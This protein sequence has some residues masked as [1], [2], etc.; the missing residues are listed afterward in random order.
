MSENTDFDFRQFIQN[1]LIDLST[2]KCHR[3]HILRGS[4]K[5]IYMVSNNDGSIEIKP[6]RYDDE[7]KELWQKCE[8][9]IDGG[10]SLESGA[11]LEQWLARNEFVLPSQYLNDLSAGTLSSDI[12]YF[13]SFDDITK[14]RQRRFENGQGCFDIQWSLSH[15]S[16]DSSNYAS[17]DTLSEARSCLGRT[18]ALQAIAG[19]YGK[20]SIGSFTLYNSHFTSQGMD[21][22]DSAIN[23]STKQTYPAVYS[24]LLEFE[25]GLNEGVVDAPRG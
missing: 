11:S 7:S 3:V 19:N 12:T 13:P 8:E 17:F 14:Y 5:P 21:R 9:Y 18:G 10:I 4:D 22:G 20:I 2:S 1:N 23:P 16:A 6:T 15:E 25:N 24:E